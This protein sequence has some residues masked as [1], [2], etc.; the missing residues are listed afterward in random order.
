VTQNGTQPVSYQELKQAQTADHSSKPVQSAVP[1][2]FSAPE[3]R[4]LLL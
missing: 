3:K 1:N 4:P 2:K